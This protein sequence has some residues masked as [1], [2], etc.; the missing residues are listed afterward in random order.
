M[1]P[2]GRLVGIVVSGTDETAVDAGARALGRTAP[3][4]ADIQVLGPAPAP[5]AMI[6]GRHRRR[7]LLKA[8]RGVTVQPV[9]RS[10]IKRAQVPKKVR[11]HIDVDPYSFM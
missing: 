3:R 10:W 8:G 4:A 5:L 11:V 2:F 9:I 6:R 7:L 1:P